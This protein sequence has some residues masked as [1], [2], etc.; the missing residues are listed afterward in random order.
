MNQII[1]YQDDLKEQLLRELLQDGYSRIRPSS[2][3]ALMYHCQLK[4]YEKG[5]LLLRAGAGKKCLFAFFK[6]ITAYYSEGK[7]IGEQSILN[8]YSEEQ[9]LL[10]LDAAQEATLCLEALEDCR[11]LKLDIFALEQIA[12]DDAALMAAYSQLLQQTFAEN[13][14]QFVDRLIHKPQERYLHLLETHPNWMKRISQKK[15]AIYLG[16]TPVSFSRIK[17]RLA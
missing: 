7:A 5:E 11:V 17:K 6:G 10:H 16:I 13:Q 14:Q 3:T 15:I 4:E 8:F 9:Y 12:R 2:K 1:S